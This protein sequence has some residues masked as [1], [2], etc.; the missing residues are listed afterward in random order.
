MDGWTD[1]RMD[2]QMDR[3][4][5]GWMDVVHRSL[6]PPETCCYTWSVRDEQGYSVVSGLH[7]RHRPC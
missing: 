5:D 1:G 4:I 7:R 6:M 3:Q 2:G